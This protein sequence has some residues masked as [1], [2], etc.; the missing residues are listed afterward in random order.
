MSPLMT[1]GRFSR[2]RQSFLR[3][4]VLFFMLCG[5]LLIAISFIDE[6]Y[7]AGGGENANDPPRDPGLPANR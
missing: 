7:C 2:S 5:A 1:G 6:T 3:A 4:L